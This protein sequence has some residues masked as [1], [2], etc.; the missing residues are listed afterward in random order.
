MKIPI[1]ARARIPMQSKLGISDF[2]DCTFYGHDHF[3]AN[4]DVNFDSDHGFA[5]SMNPTYEQLPDG[6]IIIA[7]EPVFV[8]QGSVRS[9]RFD[10]R[11]SHQNVAHQFIRTVQSKYQTWQA[12]L[13]HLINYEGDKPGG[14]DE[15][16]AEPDCIG[17][18]QFLVDEQVPYFDV[19][20]FA[21]S[22]MVY[23][24]GN[25]YAVA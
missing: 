15:E 18:Y 22:P 17:W 24:Y 21:L 13:N 20:K 19:V 25:I 2:D 7:I 12:L 11:Y 8:A 5:L 14:C 23:V 16:F 1:G 9:I 6:S 10:Y 3:D 4:L